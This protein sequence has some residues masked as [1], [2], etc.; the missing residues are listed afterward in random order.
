MLVQERSVIQGAAVQF[1]GPAVLPEHGVSNIIEWHPHGH[2]SRWAGRDIGPD[3]LLIAQV[4][5]SADAMALQRGPAGRSQAV[6]P[7]RA[8]QRAPADPAAI[9]CG[10]AAQVP[11]VQAAIPRQIP[12]DHHRPLGIAFRYMSAPE[13]IRGTRRQPSTATTEKT[14]NAAARPAGGMAGRAAGMCPAAS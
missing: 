7:V 1:I 11:D 8:H 3:L 2:Q 14:L 9:R 10:Q 6:D 13:R 5:D 4:H 12:V